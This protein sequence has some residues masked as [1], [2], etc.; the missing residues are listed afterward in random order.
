MNSERAEEA[1]TARMKQNKH[2]RQIAELTLQL[3]RMQQQSNAEP[4]KDGSDR[5]DSVGDAAETHQL[6]MQ[7]KE[8]SEEVLK[9][10]EKMSGYSSEIST[11][12]S[13]LRGA[14]DRADKA[15]SALEENMAL[16]CTDSYDRMER[17]AP[18]SGNAVRRRGQR[19]SSGGTSISA[20]MH[21]NKSER[22]GKAVDAL[23]SFSVSTGTLPSPLSSLV[24]VSN[25]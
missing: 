2:D 12:K 15:E 19:G 22:V 5:K 4:T 11:L 23:D 1:T 20:A 13:R 9:A 6:K 16:P 7:I 14:V 18:S 24:I 8:L 21:L 25:F 3:S 17:G 10:R